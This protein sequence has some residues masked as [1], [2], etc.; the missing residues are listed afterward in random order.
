[1]QTGTEDQVKEVELVVEEGEET[2]TPEA[3]ETAAAES[4]QP[5]VLETI[6]C[7]LCDGGVMR[8]AT[9]KP[10]SLNAGI[11]LLVVGVVCILTGVLAL[12][13]FFMVLG[14]VYFIVAKKPVWLCDKCESI[15]ERM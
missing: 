15:V 14:G 13:G 10:Y 6:P 2:A 8:R 11:A 4:A 1:M 7:K 5:E 3:K 9:I 12:L